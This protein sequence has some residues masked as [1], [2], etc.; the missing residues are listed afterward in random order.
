MA[1]NQGDLEKVGRMLA[2]RYGIHVV[3][4]G[5]R[6]LTDG[7]TIV[8]PMLPDCIES[9]KLLS[10]VRYYLD[11]ECGHLVGESDFKLMKKFSKSEGEASAAILDSIEDCR[12]E[13]IMADVWAGCG[14]NLRLGLKELLSRLNADEDPAKMNP[15]KQILTAIYVCGKGLEIPDWVDPEIKKIVEGHAQELQ[16]IPLW[17]N[18][19]KDLIPLAQSMTEELRQYLQ[20]MPPQPQDGM[21]EG[22][23]GQSSQSASSSSSSSGGKSDGQGSGKSKSKGKRQ[24]SKQDQDSEASPDDSTDKDN[25][26]NDDDDCWA[27]ESDE[28]EDG[29]DGEGEE[30]EPDEG[31][32]DSGDDSDSQGGDDD[33]G[34]GGEQG[35]FGAADPIEK[36]LEGFDIDDLK[37]D[38]AQ[39]VNEAVNDELQ[40]M[41]KR[42]HNGMTRPISTTLDRYLDFPHRAKPDLSREF[43]KQ[44]KSAGGAMRQ[45]LAMLLMSED[46]AWWR[47][48][49]K[50]GIPDPRRL[51]QLAA[52][53]SDRVMRKRIEKIAPNT[54]CHLLID[55]SGSMA[56]ANRIQQAVLAASAF[57]MIMEVCGHKV[58]VSVF[59]MPSVSGYKVLIDAGFVDEN[60]YADAARAVAVGLRYQPVNLYRLKNWNESV[61]RAIPKLTSAS[62]M[63]NGGTPMGEAIVMA[64]KDLASRQEKRK[65]LMVFG[66]GQPNDENYARYACKYAER[67]GLEVVLVGISYNQ[68]KT[69]YHKVANVPDVKDLSRVTMKELTKALQVGSG[70]RIRE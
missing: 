48:D 46:K 42:D 64:A 22:Q 17:A 41:T 39:A 55:G 59:Q 31:D 49:L 25:D 65:V 32:G 58:A 70:G 53:V 38:P 54:A 1:L 10:L 66:D 14:I 4:K 40:S 57:A 62:Q 43:K 16:E 61:S 7:N 68:M 3:C 26:D 2:D 34:S 63:C 29:D 28:D 11:H 52:K 12:V 23:P 56:E 30:E 5:D 18:K 21:G 6:C 15:I 19:T 33:G 50:R 9:P 35:G 36:Q 24:Q 45:K 44:A 27:E 8:L 47:S 69:L 60:G 20:Q 67:L 37:F 13:Q 51:A